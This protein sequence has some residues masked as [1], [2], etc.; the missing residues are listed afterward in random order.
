MGSG[1]AALVQIL[2]LDTCVQGESLTPSEPAVSHL[3][4]L[5][6]VLLSYVC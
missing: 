4:H 2:I 3:Q 1:A 5:D 6:I